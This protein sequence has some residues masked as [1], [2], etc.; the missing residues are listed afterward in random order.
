[1]EEF[2]GP[3]DNSKAVDAVGLFETEMYRSAMHGGHGGGKTSAFK[4]CL[5]LKRIGEAKVADS[6][7]AAVKT[8]PSP[9]CYLHLLQGCGAVS[10]V[11]TDATAFGCRNWDFACVITGVWPRDQDGTEAARAVMQWAY[12]VAADLLSISC[13]AY[14]AVLGPDPR[15]AAL[16]AKAFGPNGLR[17]ACLKHSADPRN[18]LAYVCPLPGAPMG[19]EL[20]ILVTGESCSGK[21]YCAGVWASVFTTCTRKY[22]AA[23]V[24]GISDVTKREYAAATG[25][26]LDRLLRDRV[27]KEQHR[28]AL[29]GFWQDQLRQRPRLPEEH[30]LDVV[31]GAVDLNVLLT[32]MTRITRIAKTTR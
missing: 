22:L 21:D 17:L 7:V 32:T 18:V 19:P 26:D 15:D 23:R 10:D 6:L 29:T 14:G 13:G 2:W 25:A 20:I 5:F 28:P 12:N 30:F 4:R 3:E 9:L 24:V 8:R 27:Y 11:A 16:A 31:Y 1:M